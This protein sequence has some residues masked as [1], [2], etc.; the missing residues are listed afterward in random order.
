MHNPCIIA[1][2][3]T[4]LRISGDTT[5]QLYIPGILPKGP[6]QSP[7]QNNTATGFQIDPP[8][9]LTKPLAISFMIV[10]WITCGFDFQWNQFQTLW[11]NNKFGTSTG[12]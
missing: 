12:T 1:S 2:E 7:E 9:S 11:T 10:Q 3:K 8:N 4:L 5:Y 6:S